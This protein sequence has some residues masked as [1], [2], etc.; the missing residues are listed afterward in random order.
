M[1]TR[2]RKVQCLD[3]ERGTAKSVEL[4]R[5][6]WEMRVHVKKGA[7]GLPLIRAGIK[8]LGRLASCKGRQAGRQAGMGVKLHCLCVTAS[9]TARPL[10]QTEG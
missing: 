10:S 2:L 8:F 1:S 4:D 5:H 9:I 3:R 7:E 6:S